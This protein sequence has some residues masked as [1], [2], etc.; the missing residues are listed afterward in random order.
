[1]CGSGAFFFRT[2]RSVSY[3]AVIAAGSGAANVNVTMGQG[4]LHPRPQAT[5]SFT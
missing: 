3:L 1:M 5:S 4:A 2:G